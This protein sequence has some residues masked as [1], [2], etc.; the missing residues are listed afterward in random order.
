[1]SLPKVNELE[2]RFVGQLERLVEIE[3]RAM[4]ARLRRG[5]GKPLGFATERDGWVIGRLPSL[6][7]RDLSIYA[8]IASLFAS[9]SQPHG[10]GSL[11]ESF[12]K[13][14]RVR[15]TPDG[16]PNDSVEK[17]FVALLNT[18][19]EDLGDQLRH[20]VSLLRANNIP[21]D[22]R[23]LLH[24][25]RGWDGE[26]R[27]VQVRWSRD[28]WGNAANPETDLVNEPAAESAST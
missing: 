24:D 3:D 17:R 26:R 19:L 22:W 11:G 13:L 18:N 2:D 5:L 28:F 23:S 15:A 20:A 9:H 7:H 14:G 16:K 4:L 21:I 6:S 10:E 27:W 25:I 12:R 1:M 8:T